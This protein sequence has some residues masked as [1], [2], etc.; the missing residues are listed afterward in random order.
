MSSV[1]EGMNDKHNDKV[2]ITLT[3][4]QCE[5]LS[6]FIELNMLQHIRDDDGVDNLTYVRNILNAQ[7]VF[8]EACKRE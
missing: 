3:R 8:E 2:K 7:Q 4:G 1:G 5:S 6:E